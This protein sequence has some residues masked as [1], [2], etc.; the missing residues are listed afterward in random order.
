MQ[1]PLGDLP[2]P[3]AFEK[4]SRGAKLTLARKLML[5]RGM[6]PATGRKLADK[7]ETCKSCRHLCA[8][9]GARSYYKCDLTTM[10]H[11]PATDIRVRWP[12]CVLWEAV[13]LNIIEGPK[14]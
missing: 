8:F 7:G 13:K 10:T 6:H 4:L 1:P 14:S 9:G 5:E 12:A 11:G 3:P 2:T